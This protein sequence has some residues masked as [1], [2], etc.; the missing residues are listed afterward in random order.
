MVSGQ[1]RDRHVDSLAVSQGPGPDGHLRPVRIR[2]YD[3]G[4]P[5]LWQARQPISCSIG[6]LEHR[7]AALRARRHRGTGTVQKIPDPFAC[8]LLGRPDL[9]SG[10]IV[11]QTWHSF[12]PQLIPGTGQKMR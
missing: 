11:F 2:L 6:A 7:D 3:A 5:P 1:P 8:Y 10:D 9:R 12:D 4:G